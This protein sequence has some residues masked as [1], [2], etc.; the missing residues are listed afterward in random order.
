MLTVRRHDVVIL[1]N[2]GVR[3]TR[4]HPQ[5]RLTLANLYFSVADRIGATPAR[6]YG[7]MI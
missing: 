1:R 2:I 5:N 4:W 7:S 6:N 3:L